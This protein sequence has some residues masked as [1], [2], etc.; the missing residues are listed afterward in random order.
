MARNKRRLLKRRR[1]DRDELMELL[2]RPL[3][4]EHYRRQLAWMKK[5]RLRHGRIYPGDDDYIAYLEQETGTALED[6]KD[7]WLTTCFGEPAPKF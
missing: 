7:E 1:N 5:E 2:S 6:A 4:V 3:S